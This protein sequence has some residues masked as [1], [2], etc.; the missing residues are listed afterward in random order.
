MEGSVTDKAI[1]QGSESGKQ[2]HRILTNMWLACV[3]VM[4]HALERI[5]SRKTVFVESASNS[6]NAFVRCLSVMSPQSMQN[7]KPSR[8]SKIWSCSNV[9]LWFVKIKLFSFR[10]EMSLSFWSSI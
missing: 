6:R 5:V 1:K 8:V 10:L 7:W 9:P 3:K 4:P 2:Q